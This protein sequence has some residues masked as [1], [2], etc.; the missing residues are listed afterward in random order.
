[1]MASVSSTHSDGTTTSSDSSATTATVVFGFRRGI[2]A[3]PSALN[4]WVIVTVLE[5][6]CQ[7]LFDV[8]LPI[9]ASAAAF[10]LAHPPT[11]KSPP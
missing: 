7:S 2:D 11:R 8:N 9:S 6:I 10:I 3:S 1:M 4:L 5:M